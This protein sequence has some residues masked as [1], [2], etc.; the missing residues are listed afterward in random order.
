M[1]KKIIVTMALGF[2]SAGAAGA[3]NSCQFPVVSTNFSNTSFGM[4]LATL[5]LDGKQL[6]PEVKPEVAWSLLTPWAFGLGAGFCGFIIY[7]YMLCPFIRSQWGRCEKIFGEKE[8]RW[9]LSKGILQ[10]SD[11]SLKTNQQEQL[12]LNV[13]KQEQERQVKLLKNVETAQEMAELCG[14]TEKQVISSNTQFSKINVAS[15]IVQ[16]RANEDHL[17]DVTTEKLRVFG[18][19]DGHGEPTLKDSFGKCPSGYASTRFKHSVTECAGFI[20]CTIG[21]Y[22]PNELDKGLSSLIGPDDKAVENKIQEVFSTFNTQYIAPRYDAMK[23]LAQK[24]DGCPVF[25]SRCGSDSR[26]YE[27]GSTCVLAMVVPGKTNVDDRV[28][29]AHAGDSGATVIYNDGENKPVEYAT[30]GH[31]CA[32]GKE[33]ERIKKAGGEIAGGR[34]QGELMLS[35]S[36]GDFLYSDKGLIVEPEVMIFKRSQVKC[37]LLY[38][39]GLIEALTAKSK[40]MTIS[41]LLDVLLKD[42]LYKNVEQAN[43]KIQE[44][45]VLDNKALDDLSYQLIVFN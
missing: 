17:F 6:A 19:A 35:R 25:Q 42:D 23:R 18:I 12:R 9:F 20:P 44:H 37:V 15:K 2:F 34:L 10:Q 5:P 21:A 1:V 40:A 4:V 7:K 32:L 36:F 13:E 31:T 3:G 14:L 43:S 30:V 27:G 39:D 28:V 38:S 29:I 16:N 24:K 41:K 8:S 45:C 22:L 33:L 26:G 11:D